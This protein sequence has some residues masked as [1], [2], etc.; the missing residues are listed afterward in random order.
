M[1]LLLFELIFYVYLF[2]ILSI[3]YYYLIIFIHS[4]YSF[5]GLS[6]NNKIQFLNTAWLNRNISFPTFI[7]FFVHFFTNITLFIF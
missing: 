2:I 6:K 5:F 7:L 4:P 3:M 1:Y